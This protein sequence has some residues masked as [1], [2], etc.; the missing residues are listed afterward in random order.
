MKILVVDVETSPHISAHFGR[1]KQNIPYYATLEESRIICWAAKWLGERATMFS[2]EWQVGREA[3]LT[4]IYELLCEA[5]AIVTF[6]GDKFDVKRLNSE[7]LRFG[8][9]PP[10]PYEKIDLYKQA[11]KHFAFSSNR[12]D[13]LLRELGLSPKL[14]HTGLSLWLDVRDGKKS[15][16]NKMR[17]YNVQDVRSTEEFYDY[18]LGWITPHPNWGNY[19]DDVS[20]PNTPVC[21]N[22]GST[23][24]V[25]HKIRTTKVKKY[26]QWHCQDCGKYARGRRALDKLNETEGKLSD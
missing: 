3:M 11:K 2:A 12:L 4:A 21:P 10:S 8:W 9:A 24:M 17:K 13:D 14:P 16:Q 7:F 5:D 15:A 22:C 1:W 25:R 26:R 20:D 6:N 18:M 23:R 19:V